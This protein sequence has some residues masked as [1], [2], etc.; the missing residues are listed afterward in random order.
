MS[1]LVHSPG[2]LRGVG[3]ALGAG[4]QAR[5]YFYGNR[6]YRSPQDEH[7][8]RIVEASL[9]LAVALRNEQKTGRRI[10]PIVAADHY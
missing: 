7:E 9:V 10:D 1:A 6:C 8:N 4:W 2:A 3:A 5:K